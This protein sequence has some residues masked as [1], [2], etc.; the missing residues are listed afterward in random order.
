MGGALA[1]TLG[2][3]SL[4]VGLRGALAEG[5]LVMGLGALSSV[6]ARIPRL[7]ICLICRSQLPRLPDLPRPRAVVALVMGPVAK[8]DSGTSIRII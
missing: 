1:R 3:R 7:L 6:V 5:R 2:W 4:V 8:R